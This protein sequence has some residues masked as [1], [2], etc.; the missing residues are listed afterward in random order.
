MLKFNMLQLLACSSASPSSPHGHSRGRGA[1]AKVLLG[2]LFLL[3]LSRSVFATLLAPG[4][5]TAYNACI[6]AGGGHLAC[7]AEFV[8]C[9]NGMTTWEP[10]FDGPL[11]RYGMLA[12]SRDYQP[13]EGIHVEVGRFD[14]LGGNYLAG[15]GS[16]TGVTFVYVPRDVLWGA[17]D[18]NT[19]EWS[20]IGP[21]VFNEVTSTWSIL[22]TPP[23]GAPMGYDVA[24]IMTDPTHP[25]GAGICGFH[26]QEVAAPPVEGKRGVGASLSQNPFLSDMGIVVKAFPQPAGQAV[27]LQIDIA[28]AGT[29]AVELTDMLGRK[30]ALLLPPTALT[31]GSFTRSFDIGALPAGQYIYRVSDGRRSVAGRCWKQ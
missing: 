11:G 23:A 13:G 18:M 14:Y 26:A 3:L 17:E 1:R 7:Y 28:E 19:V 20:I 2:G 21:G 4:C 22:W 10:G 5:Y 25:N 31:A 16:V 6:K 15:S 24:A 8:N 9:V 30:V 29:Y 12:V 27:S